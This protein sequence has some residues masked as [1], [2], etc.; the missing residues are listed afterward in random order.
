MLLQWK[1]SNHEV[2][3]L[4]ITLFLFCCVTEIGRMKP[5]Y[6]EVGCLGL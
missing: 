2:S 6:E 1:L 5:M 3:P 4:N